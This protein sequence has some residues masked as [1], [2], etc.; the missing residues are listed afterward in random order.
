MN[1]L[2]KILGILVLGIILFNSPLNAK[3]TKWV[4]GQIYEN[5]VIWLKNTK[6]LLPPGEQF[7]LVLSDHWSSWG[8][9][10]NGKWLISTKGNLYHQ[11]LSLNRIGSSKYLAYLLSLI[12][13]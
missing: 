5:E 7:Q 1:K 9:E 6:H 8:I 11:S 12:H 13:I 4:R 10:I 3:Q 2:K